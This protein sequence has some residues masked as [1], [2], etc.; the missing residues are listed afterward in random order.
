MKK[1][2]LLLTLAISSISCTKD[3]D[4]SED[5][6]IN[7]GSTV[8]WPVESFD[9]TTSNC[10]YDS[11]CERDFTSRTRKANFRFKYDHPSQIFIMDDLDNKIEFDKEKK[12]H[13]QENYEGNRLTFVEITTGGFYLTNYSIT[14]KGKYGETLVEGLDYNHNLANSCLVAL[15]YRK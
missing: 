1:L 14:F 10:E 15:K 3:N 5:T 9:F 8:G 11:I 7:Y 13:C 2:I 12:Y 6:D 4:V